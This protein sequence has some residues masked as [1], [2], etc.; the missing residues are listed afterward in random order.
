[1]GGLE[2][3]RG[4]EVASGTNFTDF[5]RV[6]RAVRIQGWAPCPSAASV[7]ASRLA[8]ASHLALATGLGAV[9]PVHT[10]LLGVLCERDG[11][12]QRVF[13]MPW[14]GVTKPPRSVSSAVGTWRTG[15]A[16]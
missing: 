1:M 13:C 15:Y 3:A 14:P 11:E 12:I 10:E 2:P 7:S 8:S 16:R 4:L 6:A 5:L 9:C